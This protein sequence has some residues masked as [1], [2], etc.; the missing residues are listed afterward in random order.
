MNA[1]NDSIFDDTSTDGSILQQPQQQQQHDHQQQNEQRQQQQQQE[2]PQDM[3]LL[4]ELIESREWEGVISFCNQVPDAASIGRVYAEDIL[5]LPLH[6]VL[7]Q[8]HPSWTVINLLL[9]MYPEG[10]AKKGY[11]GN[12]PLH[13]ACSNET[14]SIEILQ[15]L[16]EAYPT[17]TRLRND[18]DSLPIHLACQHLSELDSILAILQTHPEGAYL[19]DA[20]GFTALDYASASSNIGT[21]M[22]T[23]LEQMAPILVETAKAA[24]ERKSEETNQKIKGIQEAHEEYIRQLGFREEDL[25]QEFMEAQIDLQDQLSE[26]KERNISLAE[27]ILKKERTLQ[28]LQTQVDQL[29][30]MIKDERV[31]RQLEM[32]KQQQEYKEILGINTVSNNENGSA[33][34]QASSPSA[35]SLVSLRSASPSTSKSPIRTSKNVDMKTH[36]ST[37]V[38]R[39]NLQQ[40]ELAEMAKDLTYNTNMVRNLNELLTSKDE[41]I[42]ELKQENFDLKQEKQAQQTQ[43]DGLQNSLQAT[44]DELLDAKQEVQRLS[45]MYEQ[46]SEQLTEAN[47]I[48]RVQESRLASI[49]SLA[50]SLSFN[51]ESWDLDDQQKEGEAETWGH[52]PQIQQRPQSQPQP[53]RSQLPEQQPQDQL[54]EEQDQLQPSPTDEDQHI[55]S[56]FEVLEGME[57]I[58]QNDQYDHHGGN[59]NALMKQGRMSPMPN[60]KQQ[61]QQALMMA[62]DKEDYSLKTNETGLST[63]N[64]ESTLPS[65]PG[66]ESSSLSSPA[67]PPMGAT[68]QTSDD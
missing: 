41:H 53:R 62:D 2:P 45:K 23:T 9:N 22:N 24:A 47:R 38:Q 40:K 18:E 27:R 61:Q 1:L 51:I 39:Y 15:G 31:D 34:E 65:S 26:E 30:N 10:I 33:A 46:Q 11:Q 58:R 12:L 50:Q 44:Q 28:D 60:N 55:S 54:Q 32:A 68:R 17:A 42:G 63:R 25:E 37:L 43:N 14:I 16:L 48:V 64:E 67:R 13:Y 52:Q 4:F 21:S 5:N 3:G 49:K 56:R 6:E 36:L 29:T 19:R 7:K 8:P 20:D 59:H 57:T 66:E 35:R